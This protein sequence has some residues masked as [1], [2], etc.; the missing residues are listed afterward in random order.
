MN[1]D[2]N[3]THVT[4]MLCIA[5]YVRTDGWLYDDQFEEKKVEQGHGCNIPFSFELTITIRM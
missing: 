2:A 1:H 5:S 4:C 3:E